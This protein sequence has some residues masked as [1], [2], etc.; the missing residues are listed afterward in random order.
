MGV[1]WEVRRKVFLQVTDE[2]RPKPGGA[3]RK[4]IPGRSQ[5]ELRVRGGGGGGL[6]TCGPTT[7]ELLC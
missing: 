1:G 6:V 7:W 3:G 4:G 2:Q 5:L